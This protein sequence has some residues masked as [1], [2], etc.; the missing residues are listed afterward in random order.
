MTQSK[1]SL[2]DL[3]KENPSQ[4]GDPVSMKAETSSTT[5]GPNNRGA[6]T[7]SDS[8]NYTNSSG[9]NKVSEIQTKAGAGVMMTGDEGKGTQSSGQ[10]GGEQ[11]K[12]GKAPNEEKGTLGDSM[13][14][15][16]EKNPT[17]L[18]DPI[19]MKAE[20]SETEVTEQDRGAKG[21]S[22]EAKEKSKL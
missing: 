14:K 17:A 6:S 8:P 11:G 22:R 12:G 4:L 3:A 19:S 1:K 9:S 16:V 7:S 10:K 21:I 2:S 15:M 18:G 20:K 13:K 5:K